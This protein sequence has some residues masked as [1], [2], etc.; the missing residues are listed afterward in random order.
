MQGFIKKKDKTGRI[1]STLRPWPLTSFPIE[2][3]G[4]ICEGLRFLRIIIL[5]CVK[6]HKFQLK[7]VKFLKKETEINKNLILEK[8]LYKKHRLK[9]I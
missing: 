3:H 6:I 5:D 9:L 2:V 1:F 4:L 8:T 7:F